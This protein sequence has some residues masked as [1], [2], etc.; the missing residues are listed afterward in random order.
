M[1]PTGLALLLAFVTSLSI[2]QSLPPPSRTVFKCEDGKKTYYSD[3]P[4]LGAK[5][6]DVTPTRGMNKSTGRELIGSDVEREQRREQIAEG[7]KPLTGMNA[8][9]MDQFGRRMQ[10]SSEAQQACRRLDQAL[11]VAE[12]SERAAQGTS[13]L[14]AAQ[15]RLLRLRQQFRDLRCQ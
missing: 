15:L 13:E 5:K 9:Q 12:Q 11:P 14:P 3:S 1:R 4:C 10:L 7:I 6:L 8:Q 2:A